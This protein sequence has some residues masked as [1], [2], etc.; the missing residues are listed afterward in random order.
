MEN[1]LPQRLQ[2]YVNGSFE[3][4][5]LIQK[6]I[7]QLVRGD[8]P[9]FDAVYGCSSKMPVLSDLRMQFGSGVYIGDLPSDQRDAI[10]AD[11][12]FIQA[13]VDTNTRPI[14]GVGSVI[15]SFDELDTVLLAMFGG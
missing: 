5:V 11:L 2:E 12:E 9:L 15:K 14:P 6:R 3:R 13:L 8:A 1:T 7:R 4:T 10:G